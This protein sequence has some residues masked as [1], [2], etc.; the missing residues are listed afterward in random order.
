MAATALKIKATYASVA[1]SAVQKSANSKAARCSDEHSKSAGRAPQKFRKSHSSRKTN[2]PIT[3]G[4]PRSDQSAKV[5]LES[6][7]RCAPKASSN[8]FDSAKPKRRIAPEQQRE[9]ELKSR[10]RRVIAA[11]QTRFQTQ[12]S[13]PR[14]AADTT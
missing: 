6:L 12:L 10:A 11:S 8:I 9:P 5:E 13:G 4:E 1:R 14:H 7:P 2:E 3:L